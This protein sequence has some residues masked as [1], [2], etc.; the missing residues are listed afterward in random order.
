MS[1][2]TLDPAGS[3]PQTV[4][5]TEAEEAP[6][7]QDTP[8][9][10]TEEAASSPATD[11]PTSMLDAVRTALEPD[12]GNGGS[13]SQEPGRETP[14]RNP[15]PSQTDEGTAQGTE[16]SQGADEP[17][18]LTDEEFKKLKPKTQRRIKTLS[19]QV[20]EKSEEIEQ[21]RPEVEA[22]RELMSSTKDAG[23]TDTEV[24]TGLEIMRQVKLNPAKAAEMLAP[25][26]Q[27]LRQ[28]LG[29]D[30]PDDIR[31]LVATGQL[32]QAHAQEL[33]RQR[34]T[35]RLSQEQAT[36]STEA[37]T[38]ERQ[39]SAEAE[40]QRQMQSALHQWDTNWQSTDPDYERMAPFVADRFQTLVA[41]AIRG[42]NPPKDAAAV[43]AIA[44]QA[45]KDVAASM[46]AFAKPKA[47]TNQQ[48]Q[49]GSRS[50]EPKPEPQSMLEAIKQGAGV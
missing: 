17:D 22:Y 20:K 8:N 4:P 38:A 21:L 14:V 31:Q 40:A 47:P 37:L 12:E 23:L 18:D 34:A 9:T 19:S 3:S 13:S 43:V 50:S 44:E 42:P 11:E 48:P 16:A 26:V 36:R 5:D 2:L 32:S 45:R 49:P 29:M 24:S 33:S 10:E 46:G 41:A 28:Q 15:D 39:R 30:L 6:V 1:D 35:A 7:S 25:Y 27:E